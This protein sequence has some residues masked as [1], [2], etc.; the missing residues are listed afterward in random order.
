MNLYTQ[1]IELFGDA[2]ANEYRFPYR[3]PQVQAIS[4]A[5]NQ[6]KPS[7]ITLNAS[8]ETPVIRT[9]SRLDGD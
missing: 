3:V 9:E 5:A 8:I 7:P 2:K 4:Q 6:P 1:A